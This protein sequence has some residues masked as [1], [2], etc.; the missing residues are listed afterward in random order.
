MV[1][2]IL[3]IH[4][5]MFQLFW[6]FN[7]FPKAELKKMY[8]KI[9]HSLSYNEQQATHMVMVW[10][11]WHSGPNTTNK[12]FIQEPAVCST[13]VVAFILC[14]FIYYIFR[15]T[16]THTTSVCEFFGPTAFR[17]NTATQ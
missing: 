8:K 15:R 17:S 6:G 14:Y 2:R 16:R 5:V 9:K 3:Y 13:L 4:S 7:L 10:W 11:H 1:P 12:N